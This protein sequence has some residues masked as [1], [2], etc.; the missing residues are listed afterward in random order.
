[1]NNTE[2]LD[3]FNPQPQASSLGNI[4]PPQ[5]TSSFQPQTQTPQ[6]SYDT[7]PPRRGVKGLIITLLVLILVFGGIL[8]GTIMVAYGMVSI[9]ND[10]LQRRISHFV[11]SIPFM[12]K[13]AEFIFAKVFDATA[14]EVVE[15][16]DID[17]SLAV[18][19]SNVGML[20]TIPG[21]NS[22]NFDLKISGPISFKD[23][24]NEA[25]IKINMNPGFDAGFIANE[26]RLYFSL[27]RLDLFLRVFLDIENTGYGELI[28]KWIHYDIESLESSA[29]SMLDEDI[30]DRDSEY[31]GRFLS[32]L[33]KAGFFDKFVVTSDQLDGHAVYK[34]TLSMT[35]AEFQRMY[36]DV[37][38]TLEPESYIKTLV[39]ENTI[40]NSISNIR[41]QIM[42]DKNTYF[43]RQLATSFR[44]E[45]KPLTASSVLGTSTIQVLP[46]AP[47]PPG[48]DGHIDIA[49]SMKADQL[50]EDFNI[51]APSGS[52]SIEEA[53]QIIMS[54]MNNAGAGF[55]AMDDF[56]SS[57]FDEIS[58]P[59]NMNDF[60]MDYYGIN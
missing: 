7:Q 12:P 49:L 30:Q 42:V 9:G 17:L 50:N 2:P 19:A 10:E 28:G 1:M 48:L 36:S 15:S 5:N 20:S 43:A 13:N 52:I 38:R 54:G 27:T 31:E 35:G 3:M 4:Q 47:P 51:T 56:D 60:E 57:G 8:G 29:R 58:P 41:V 23:D 24:K 34:L 33:S 26:D 18:T 59:V 37:I 44:V 16:A 14:S 53:M 21:L 6:V 22:T 55:P 45:L 39:E 25:D 46:V 11:Q 32:A 40:E